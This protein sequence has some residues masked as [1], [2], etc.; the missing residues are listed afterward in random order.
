MSATTIPGLMSS[1]SIAREGAFFRFP[2]RALE[3][4]GAADAHHRRD[5]PAAD[6]MP[7][8]GR[9]RCRQ[10]QHHHDQ[11]ACDSSHMI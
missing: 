4:R 2:F 1:A 8:L 10:H 7:R 3:P 11:Q 6:R 5:D 9:D